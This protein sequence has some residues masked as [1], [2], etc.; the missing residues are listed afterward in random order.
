VKESVYG[1]FPGGDP[2]KFEPDAEVCTPEELAA[3]RE[4]CAA[5]DAAGDVDCPPG[6]GALVR[7]GEV[8]GIWHGGPF[9]VGSYEIE[10]DHDDACPA[11]A[12]GSPV[13]CGCGF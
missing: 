6:H 1:Y 3:H 7:D 4:A 8:I 2:R 10:V 11:L 9:G 13:D 5:A 12:T